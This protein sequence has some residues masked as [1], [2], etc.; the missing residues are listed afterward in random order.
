MKIS[1][2]IINSIFENSVFPFDIKEL[3]LTQKNINFNIFNQ[4]MIKWFDEINS[5]YIF[6]FDLMMYLKKVLNMSFNFIVDVDY[7]ESCYCYFNDKKRLIKFHINP[8]QLNYQLYKYRLEIDQIYQIKGIQLKF[9]NFFNEII[10]PDNEYYQLINSNEI[11]EISF[12]K[13]YNKPFFPNTFNSKIES[14]IFGSNFNQELEKDVLPNKLTHLILGN[15]FNQELDN[16]P[17]SVIHLTI[18]KKFNKKINLSEFPNLI[19]L[20]IPK[21]YYFLNYIKKNK[22]VIIL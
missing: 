21:T 5:E 11:K 13:E 17:K 19:E 10:Y 1:K 3:L 4:I 22:N 2:Q 16:I 9:S 7:E 12:G 8:S 18:G 14:I 20:K 6:G 15:D